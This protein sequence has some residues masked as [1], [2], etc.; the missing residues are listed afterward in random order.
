M[1]GI[2]SEKGRERVCVSDHAQRRAEQAGPARLQKQ[3]K[4]E[5][6]RLCSAVINNAQ[7]HSL[8]YKSY[9]T[10]VNVDRR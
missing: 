10:G 3:T 2:E 5:R 6:W 8:L 4:S 7:T 9:I 1:G